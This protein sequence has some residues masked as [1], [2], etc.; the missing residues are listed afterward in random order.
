[1]TRDE[2]REWCAFME[3]RMGWS[4]SKA[5][6]AWALGVSL[7]TLRNWLY[8]DNRPIPRTVAILCA[9]LQVQAESTQPPPE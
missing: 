4:K 1:M 6:H 2:F 7:D 9:L 8:R 5:E 3:R